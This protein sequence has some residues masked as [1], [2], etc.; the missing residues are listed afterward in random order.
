MYE[1][2]ANSGLH[3]YELVS[4]AVSYSEGEIVIT[5][6]TPE[7]VDES[8]QISDFASFKISH[9]EPWGR[10]KY[11]VFSNLYRIKAG[12][13]LCEMELNSGDIVQIEFQE[14]DLR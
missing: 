3:D 11:I 2:I 13:T 1:K 4:I 14:G 9:Q 7:N 12:L 5:L 8:I 6:R 10:G